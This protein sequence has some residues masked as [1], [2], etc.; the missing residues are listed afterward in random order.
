MGEETA[1]KASSRKNA[2]SR[3]HLVFGW[4]QL[5]VFLSL[6]IALGMMQGF[7]VRWYPDV[8]QETRRLMLTFAHT[9]GTLIRLKTLSRS[10]SVTRLAT[11]TSQVAGTPPDRFSSPV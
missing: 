10:W 8:D 9:H 7:K 2:C 1:S 4:W 11:R 3:V 5:I 6:R